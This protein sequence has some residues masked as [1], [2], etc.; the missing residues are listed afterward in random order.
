MLDVNLDVST[1][2]SPLMKMLKK[3]APAWG[4]EQD[5]AVWKIKGISS[6]VKT[7]HIPSDGQ[8]ILQ[9]DASNDYWSAFLLEEKE[10]QRKVC[11]HASGKFKE[12]EQH[13]H[14]TFKEILAVKNGIKKFNFF[15]IHTEFQ[16]KMDMR[17]FP[18]I[19]QLNPKV[20]PNLQILRWS[21]W[22]SPY[23]F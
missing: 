4:K 6:D 8:M 20:I 1:Y 15:H 3:N 18:K 16:I 2:I 17:A 5:D 9:N 21:Q 13:Y 7:L 22:F 12:A 11:E 23:K 19:V 14:S 10:G